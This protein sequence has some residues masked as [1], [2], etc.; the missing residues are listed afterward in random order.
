MFVVFFNSRKLL[1]LYFFY[2]FFK[3]GSGFRVKKA[4]GSGSALLET[5]GFGYAKKK[6]PIHIPDFYVFI[7]KSNVNFSSPRRMIYPTLARVKN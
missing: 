1:I 4:T 3:A 5:A 6:M 7:I 2:R